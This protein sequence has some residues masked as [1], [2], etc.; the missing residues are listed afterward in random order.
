MSESRENRVALVTGGAK[1]IGREIS[2]ALA[3]AGFDVLVHCNRSINEAQHTAEAVR[4]LGV[5]STVIQADY[6]DLSSLKELA[7]VIS[8]E[9]GRLDLLVNNASAYPDPERIQALGGVLSETVEHLEL[10]LAVNAKAPFFLIQQLAPLLQY[11][12]P[13]QIINILDRA[14]RKPQPSR[15]AYS[16][17]R[18]AFNALA[19]IVRQSLSGIRVNNVELGW[20]LPG[21]GMTAQERMSRTWAGAQP[22]TEAVVRL[23]CDPGADGQTILI[24]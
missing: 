17:S 11:P 12:G 24:G 6:L 22:V 9:F 4:A 16:I 14:G 23:A 21:E 3:Q 18:A 2:L 10:M 5:K 1:R 15:A 19:A 13:G 8:R 20:V 7:L